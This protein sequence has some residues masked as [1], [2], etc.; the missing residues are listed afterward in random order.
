MKK[1]KEIGEKRLIDEII[2]PLF[3][4]GNDLYS[5]G[6]DCA[7]V[8]LS[9]EEVVCFSTD[10]IP[11]DLIAFKL[12]LINYFDL[13]YYLAV[14]NISDVVASGT[15]PHSLLLNLAF[16]PDFLLSEFKNLLNGIKKAADNYNVAIIGGDLSS[17]PVISFSATSI[18]KGKKSSLFHRKGSHEGDLIYCC[19]HLGLT[20]T[21]FNYFLN[22]K[23]KGCLLNSDEEYLLINQFK[24]PK[25]RIKTANYLNENFDRVTSMDNT[26]GIGQ[27]LSELSKINTLAYVLDEEKLPIH[28]ITYKVSKF[29]NVSPIEIAIGPGADFQLIGTVNNKQLF[30]TDIKIIGKVKNGK[31][32]YLKSKSGELTKCKIEGWNYYDSNR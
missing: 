19:D 1:I 9:N 26:D 4:P 22:A 2:K 11:H 29:L 7:V 13:G 25:A 6:D 3:N 28:P 30:S 15:E 17:C 16:P 18:G 21:S 14:L 27:S 31:G 23:P 24:K 10:R 8:E 5:I 20:S 12:G 32:V